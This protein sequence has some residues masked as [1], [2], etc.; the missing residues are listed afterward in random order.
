METTHALGFFLQEVEK[1]NRRHFSVWSR[2]L[3]GPTH[4]HHLR[5]A[6]PV[7]CACREVVRVQTSDLSPW[8]ERRP[9]SGLGSKPL[10]FMGLSA[11]T[12][13]AAAGGRGRAEPWRGDV[14]EA[15]VLP[16]RHC[17][18]SRQTRF[19]SAMCGGLG[20]GSSDWGSC[21]HSSRRK[22][23]GDSLPW[24]TRAL[25]SWTCWGASGAGGGRAPPGR[26]GSPVS[27]RAGCR[28]SL[29]QG[30]PR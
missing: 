15:R 12:V 13:T 20:E 21:L 19:N 25:D 8:T 9:L 16:G 30:P 6:S 17:C 23:G 5:S 28:H 24:T 26:P 18:V 3:L 10:V 22:P 7:S 1:L 27:W 4:C 14:V 11:W 2:C 29:P